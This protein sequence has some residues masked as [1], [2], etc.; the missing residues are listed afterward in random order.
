MATVDY[1][2]TS[3]YSN[4]SQNFK[5][6]EL[7]EPPL[8]TDTLDEVQ[9]DLVIEEKYNRRPDLL[10]HDLYGNSRLWWVFVHYN[11]NKIKDPIFD[12]T[13]GLKITVP[14]NVQTSGVR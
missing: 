13:S 7:Y 1:K 10:A 9:F 8:T 3:N 11:R 14:R 6:L 5:Y 4:T 12:F 2:P